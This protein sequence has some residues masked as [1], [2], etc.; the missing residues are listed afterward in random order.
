[1]RYQNEELVDRLTDLDPRYESMEDLRIGRMLDQYGIPF[2]YKQP[3]VV[4]QNGRNETHRPA[5]TLPS[6]GGLVIDYAPGT[7]QPQPR[8]TLSKDQV[9]RYNQ[10]PA[11][12]LG[13]PDL[14]KPKWN[15]LLYERL[16]RAYRAIVDPIRYELA[17]TPK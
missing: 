2:F 5:F 10:I 16:Q 13:P 17:G 7:E 15:Q 1:M 8:E 9:Y 4:Y 14:D 3:T 12:V 6:Y 11:V